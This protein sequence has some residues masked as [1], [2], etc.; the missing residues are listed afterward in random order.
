MIK[1]WV[2]NF[3]TPIVA[4]VLIAACGGG[5][6]GGP[7]P[8]GGVAT[9]A[10]DAGLTVDQY[11]ALLAGELYF[12]VHSTANSGGEI[13][14]QLSDPGA[15]VTVRTA[16]L[17]GAQEVPPPAVPTTGTGK[18]AVVVDNT[19]REISGGFTF[20]GLT[21]NASAAHIHREV[22]GT[23]GPVVI[24]LTLVNDA[25]GVP[26]AAI[27]PPGTVLSQELF[28]A[29]PN[30]ELYFNVHT[31]NNNPSGEIRGQLTG[32]TGFDV[33]TA[34]LTGDQ[35]VPP[36]TTSATGKAAL[37][38]DSATMGII[39]AAETFGGMV[40]PTAS[41]IHQAPVG[42]NGDVIVPLTFGPLQ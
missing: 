10:P 16:T 5:G 8:V 26:F 6:G 3:L 27:V 18:G 40:S 41:H 33:A 2:F 37:V 25:M 22:A 9:A 7:V 28:D 1:K 13:R 20:T 12:N 39:I 21:E 14:G 29:L 42:V 11:N 31:P 36:V 19:T 24:P 34:T 30:D 17:D 23:A 32:T 38:V 35:E 15:T 4:T